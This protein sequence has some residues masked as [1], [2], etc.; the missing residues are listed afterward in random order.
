MTNSSAELYDV[1]IA[2]GGPGG[3][4]LAALLARETQLRV[5]VLEAERFPRD[6][7]GESFVHP[8]IP[9]LERSGALGKVLASE[10]WVKKYGGYYAWDPAQPWATYFEH[11]QHENDGFYRWAIHVNRAE[12]DQILLDH[13]AASGA[14]VREE[15]PVTAVERVGDHT[16]V[17]LGE[18]GEVRCRLFVNAT[19]RTSNTTISGEK[20][21]LSAYRN[22]AIWGH[23]RDAKPAQSLAGDW[24]IFKEEDLSPIGNFAFDD[25][26]VWYIPV[27]RMVDGVRVRA[28]SVGIVTDPA[29]LKQPGKDFRDPAL[30][31]AT[32]RE[33]PLLRELVGD[34]TLIGDT[35]HTATNYSRISGKMCDWESKEIRIGDAAFF[36]DPLF[37]SGV[38]FA[39]IHATAAALLIKLTFD[40]ATPGACPA[41]SV[42]RLRGQLARR[43]ACLRGGDRSVV[44]RD[45]PG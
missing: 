5:L 39:I 18:R 32:V 37:S 42:G 16:R 25:G 6:H 44:P 29:A 33:I 35:L 30:F 38:N 23:V 8:I 28:H 9:N 26:W 41:R 13:A 40:E 11:E 7:I 3:A 19:G 12:F 27:P 24:N 14:E 17:T 45:F 4:T 21:F 2:G 1:V 15:T 22:I 20:A 10:C 43:R 36:V 34:A 31:M